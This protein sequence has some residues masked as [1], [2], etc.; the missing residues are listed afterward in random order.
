LALLRAVQTT[1]LPW[2]ALA[3]LLLGLAGLAR[4][5]GQAVLLVL[6]LTLLL[7]LKSW[8]RAAFLSLVVAIGFSAVTMPW[9]LRNYVQNGSFESAGALGQTLVGRISRHDEGFILPSP[10]SPSPAVDPTRVEARALILRQMTREARPSAINH[11]LRETYGWTEADANRAMRDVCLEII[12]AQKE[13]YVTGTLVKARRLLWGEQEDFIGKHW[14]ERKSR[15]LR[16]D[17]VTNASIAHLL[18]PPSP[19][20]EA[21][22]YTAGAMMDLVSPHSLRWPLLALLV[23]G[24]VGGLRTANRW[25]TVFVML[26]VLALI[27]TAA[28]LVGFVPRYRYPA[29]PFLAVLIGGGFAWLLAL[30]QSALN[31]GRFARSRSARTPLT[32]TAGPA[33]PAAT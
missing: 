12:T 31:A 6:P 9:M 27:L 19:L 22:K 18:S 16:D 13:R 24:L 14:G 10:D 33:R 4:P 32:Q 3:G 7:A 1:S 30:A 26:I 20:Q 25:A 21:E 2:F 15:E 11:R 28:A 5:V 17:W 8:R 29:D 23:A